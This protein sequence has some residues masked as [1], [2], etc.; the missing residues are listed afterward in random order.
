MLTRRIF[1][2]LGAAFATTAA[3][4]PSWG[5]RAVAFGISDALSTRHAALAEVWDA[6]AR[7][8]DRC[9]SEVYEGRQPKIL[10]GRRPD[11]DEAIADWVASYRAMLSAANGIFQ[12]PARNSADVILKYHLMD[13]LAWFRFERLSDSL[14]AAGGY[15]WHFIV[16]REA[17]AF[18]LDLNPF[19]YWEVSPYATIDG[20]RHSPKWAAVG[21]WRTEQYGARV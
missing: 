17:A 4:R 15:T 20:N 16:E 10:L 12:E 8:Y 2:V 11:W 7:V 6:A 14:E 19:W 3:C 1:T 21:R 18:G 9:K 13:D 5:A